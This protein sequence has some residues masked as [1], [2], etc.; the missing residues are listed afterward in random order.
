VTV[1]DREA[2]GPGLPDGPEPGMPEDV[3]EGAAVTTAVSG[4]RGWRSLVVGAGAYL[5]LSVALWWNV[6]SGHPTSTTTCGCGDTSLFTWFLEWPAYALSHGLNPLHSDYLFHPSGIN[7]LSN[8]AVVGLGIVLAPVTW[9]FGPIAAV[10]VALTLSPFLSALAMYVLLRR[11]VSWSPAAFIGGLLYGF[12]PFIVVSLTDAHL[13]LGFAAVPPL[14]VLCLDELFVRQ[15][16]SP[17][18]LGLAVGGLALVQLSVGTEVL[19]ITIVCAGFGSLLVVLWGLTH[20]EVWTARAPYAIRGAAT[21]LVSSAVLL[22]YP[23]WYALAGPTHLSGSVWGSGLLSYG[24]N[25]LGLFVH[26]MTPSARITTLTHQFGGY[27]APTLSEQYLGWGLVAVLAVGLVVWWRDLRLWLFAAVAVLAA[28]LSLGLSFHGWTLWRLMVHAPLMGNVI[29]SRFGIVV[30]LCAAV[31]LGVVC[32]HVHRTVAPPGANVPALRTA[33][34]AVVTVAV[35]ALALVPIVSYFADGLPLTVTPVNPPQWF[36]TVAPHLPGHQV[37]LVF[38]FAFRQSNMTWQAVD[39]MHYA[40]VGGGGPDSISSRAGK[41]RV[42]E[43]DLADISLAGG[44]QT[45][46]PAEVAAV[47]SAIEGW[48]V[49]GVV[50]PDPSRLP[51]Y[52]QVFAVRAIVVLVTAATGQAPTYTAGAWVWTDIDRA[53]PPTSVSATGLAQCSAGTASGSVASI[54][55]SAACVLAPTAPA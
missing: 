14:L 37:L 54:D 44:P 20:R 53:G 3:V 1:V 8:T 9:L 7:L 51:E 17:W 15:R 52:E 55:A 29:P 6:W 43:Q 28:F 23:A 21:A 18:A 39:E 19:V 2:A 50:L 35:A 13:M 42:G 32:D 40:M 12:S 10:N 30:Y 5:V 16:W 46:V 27:Q 34:A 11:W 24:G 33:L 26:P 45:V 31:M 49:T 48:G 47:R 38:P 25:T 41:E 4:V 22:A 36:R